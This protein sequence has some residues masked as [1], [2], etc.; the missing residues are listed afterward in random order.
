M[1]DLQPWTSDRPAVGPGTVPAHEFVL[2][3]AAASA[4]SRPWSTPRPA[5]P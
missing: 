4:T 5:G 3:H 2:E 1:T